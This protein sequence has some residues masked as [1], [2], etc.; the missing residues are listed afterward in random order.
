MLFI[1]RQK[2]NWFSSG[3]EIYVAVFIMLLANIQCKKFVQLDPPSTQIVTASVFSNNDAATAAVTSIYT[4][5]Q[6]ESWNMSQ[7]CGLLSDEL[8]SSSTNNGVQLYYLNNLFPSMAPLPGP[9]QS[10]YNYIYQCNAAMEGLRAYG[11]SNSIIP[12]RLI[13][14]AKFVRAFWYFYLVNCYGDVPLATTTNYAVNALLRRSSKPEVYRQIILDLKDAQQGL[15]DD[16]VD[17]SDTTITQDR[18]RPTSAAAT[19]LLARVYL[20]TDS[21]ANAELEASKVITNSRYKLVPNPDSVFL[22]NSQEAIWQLGIPDPSNQNTMDAF[23][24][25]LTA[26]PGGGDANTRTVTIN[27]VLLNS[28]ESGDKRLTSWIGKI[29]VSSP[30][31]TYY[32]PYKYKNITSNITEFTTVL[33]LGEQYLILAEAKV[34]QNKELDSAKIVLNAIRERAGLPEYSGTPDQQSLLAAILHE[35]QTELFVEWG[36]RWFDLIRTGNIDPVMNVVAPRKGSVW[37][38]VYALYPI[39]QNEITQ[40]PNLLQNPGYN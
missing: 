25:V 21:F 15:S 37:N 8:V 16:Y 10:A 23:N 28:F 6:S 26:A 35:R 2:S 30:D 14:E 4:Q 24:F 1:N 7:N 12:Q 38:T 18:I 20:Y 22:M 33:R 34:R 13:A 19:A 27:P 29:H 3:G 32:F 5:M 17:A 11:T 40:D 36:H 9:W 39:P 31:T